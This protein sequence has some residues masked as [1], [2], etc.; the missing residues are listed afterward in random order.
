MATVAARVDRLV[1]E[2]NIFRECFPEYRDEPVVGILAS[3]AVEESVL[4]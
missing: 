1:E 3:L 4:S 2:I